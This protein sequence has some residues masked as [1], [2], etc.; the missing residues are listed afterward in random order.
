MPLSFCVLILK[1]F[2]SL[3]FS[4]SLIFCSSSMSSY[5]SV[6]TCYVSLCGHFS[7]CNYSSFDTQDK[8]HLG[9]LF[10]H[11]LSPKSSICCCCFVLGVCLFVC[12]LACLLVFVCF[13][14]FGFF[15]FLLSFVCFCVC[16]RFF[17]LVW[18]LFLFLLFL[19]LK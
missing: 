6:I 2:C 5:Q 18:F 14:F 7:V 16:E 17:A 3:W 4:A 15:S 19:L 1:G 13:G 10:L 8:I 11:L 9:F 12:L